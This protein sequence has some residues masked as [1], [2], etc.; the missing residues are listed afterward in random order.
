MFENYNQSKEK[1]LQYLAD[2]ITQTRELDMPLIDNQL[3]QYVLDIR[4]LRFHIA[5]VED[6]KRGKSTLMNSL[7]GEAVLPVK[8]IP[9][10][11]FVID[12][13]VNHSRED[14]EIICKDS[15]GTTLRNL[16]KKS[17]GVRDFLNRYAT[18][19]SPFQSVCITGPFPDA[20]SFLTEGC[21]LRDT[22]GAEAL[23]DG[24]SG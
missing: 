22:P 4:S 21:T 2:C 19:D 15:Q 10:I 23:L 18:Q 24:E 6:I 13:R 14:Y 16:F 12:L 17:E 9:T 1:I 8:P 5:V 11:G 20:R 7:L 3:E